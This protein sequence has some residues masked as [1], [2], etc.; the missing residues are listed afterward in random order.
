MPRLTITLSDARHRALKE[1]AA[2]RR[3]S[4]AS[5]IEESLEASGIKDSV[6]AAALMARA[7][8][9]AGMTADEAM[10]L[11]VRETRAARSP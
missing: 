9:A 8:E 6:S 4:I 5:I 7:R 2:R 3:Q 10:A 1:A 11:A